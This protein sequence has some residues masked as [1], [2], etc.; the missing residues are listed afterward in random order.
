MISVKN[1]DA[2]SALVEHTNTGHWMDFKNTKT[3]AKVNHEIP[4]I[5]REAIEIEIRDHSL[6][7]RDDSKRLPTTWK[8]ILSSFKVPPKL[9]ISKAPSRRQIT[10]TTTQHNPPVVAQERIEQHCTR[11]TRSQAR[12]AIAQ[13]ERGGGNAEH[14]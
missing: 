1:K 8:P 7:T 4:R 6:N 10:S 5:Y 11:V 2:A 12:A 14:I 3:I 9:P 13:V